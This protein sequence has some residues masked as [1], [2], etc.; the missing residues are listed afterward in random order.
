MDYIIQNLDNMVKLLIIMFFLSLLIGSK[1]LLWCSFVFFSILTQSIPFII[2]TCIIALYNIFFSQK[3]VDAR[4]QKRERKQRQK[5]IQE[6]EEQYKKDLFHLKNEISHMSKD[7]AIKYLIQLLNNRAVNELKDEH[8]NHEWDVISIYDDSY[9]EYSTKECICKK[10]FYKRLFD[11]C[12]EECFT[13][14]YIG[15][16]QYKIA[17][18]INR[19]GFDESI[20]NSL[21]NTHYYRPDA[22]L[23][24]IYRD[25][26][27]VD[28]TR[29]DRLIN[30][31]ITYKEE[32]DILL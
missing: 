9:E 28:A 16:L 11:V 32:I 1:K 15:S 12:Q 18:V 24:C 7:D 25:F 14:S 4:K 23:Y 29:I 30:G 13:D 27:I 22:L 20:I 19:F 10:C 17:R 8:C 26:D 5:Q 21:L 3:E 6:E 2:V 31:E